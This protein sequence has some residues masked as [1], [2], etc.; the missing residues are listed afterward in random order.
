[1]HFL[2]H[3]AASACDTFPLA[4]EYFAFQWGTI[5][6]CGS[7]VSIDVM[8]DK[9]V[10]M[11]HKQMKPTTKIAMCHDWV[12]AFTPE[13]FE[14]VRN[15]A[16]HCPDW[17]FHYFHFAF[18]M[19][20]STQEQF[21]RCD[22]VFNLSAPISRRIRRTISGPEVLF[23]VLKP[24]ANEVII[25][26]DN[27][28]IGR[29]AAEHLLARGFGKFGFVGWSNGLPD[30]WRD[31]SQIRGDEFRATL[32]KAGCGCEVCPAKWPGPWN[33]RD[34]ISGWLKSLPKPAGL[35]CANDIIAKEILAMCRRC[36]ICVPEDIGV[37]GVDNSQALCETASPPLSSII[38]NW[39]R[40]GFEGANWISRLLKGKRPPPNRTVLI[41]PE[42]VCTRQSSNVQAFDDRDVADA[43][44]Y[45]QQHACE[46][47]T[48]KEVLAHVPIDRRR[49][50]RA[51]RRK[52]GH[53]PHDEIRRIQIDRAKTLL[54]ET[55]IPLS[56]VAQNIGLSTCHFCR[57]FHEATG[58]SPMTFRRSSR[59]VPR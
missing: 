32:T 13:I 40:M 18:E 20:D 14:G 10:E 2:L 27:Q 37:L 59:L 17:A 47:T 55:D 45:I 52:L 25:D 23:F 56:G 12:A 48:I 44:A 24:R 41:P 16:L 29:L 31:W 4:T 58:K 26:C 15:F 53:S 49:L 6:I 3:R 39:Q 34:S 57:F 50:E 1:V 22:A 28:A 11:R 7:H 8:R 33:S 30:S 42:G 46:G 38:I 35:F 36:A 5:Y 51:V 54:T 19:P 21:Q 9:I 43:L